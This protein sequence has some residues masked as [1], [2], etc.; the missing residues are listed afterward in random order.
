MPVYN[1]SKFLVEA[2]DSILNQTFNDFEFL[3]IDDGSTDQSIDQIKSYDDPRIQLIVNRKNIGQSATLNKGLDLKGG[4]IF[5]FNS[6]KSFFCS[7]DKTPS[8]LIIFNLN[9]LIKN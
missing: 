3:I 9:N 4:I 7:C 2:I 8:V 5:L 6:K 1:G